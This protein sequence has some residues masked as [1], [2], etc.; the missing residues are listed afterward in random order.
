MED[1]KGGVFV[2]ENGS[3]FLVFDD[4]KVVPSSLVTS[5]Q[6]LLQL[7]YSDLNQLEEV[8]QNIGKQ[9]VMLLF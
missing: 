8:T 6:L 5:M 4:L 9:E 1:T 2:R 7:G 3:M